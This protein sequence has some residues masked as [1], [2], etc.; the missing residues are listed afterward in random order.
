M[1]LAPFSNIRK[2]NSKA[3]DQEL[4]ESYIELGSVWKVAERFGMLGQSVHERLVKLEIRLKHPRITE[5]EK[6]LILEFYEKGFKTGSG[7]LKKFSES[8]GRTVPLISRTAKELGLSSLNRKVCDSQLERQSKKHKEWHLNNEHPRGMLGKTHSP[9]YC[10]EVGLRAKKQWNDFSSS[11][12]REVIFKSLKTRL[13]SQGT[14]APKKGGA[15]VSWK[16]GWRVIGSQSKY[17]R[18]RWEANYARYLE[19]LKV[20]GVIYDWLHE[21][22]TFWFDEIKR[23]CVTYLPDFKIIEKDGSHHWVEV[24]GWMD[25]RSK[26]KLSRFK[27]YYPNEKLRVVDAKWFK[28]NNRKMQGLIPTWEAG[29]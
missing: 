19:F 25:D 10:K 28:E 15:D 8:L 7:D 23:G 21:P 2:P 16:Q 3:S 17:Y 22:Q 1:T 14:L 11:R 26:T 9:E 29:K 24:K 18:S 4:I 6:E 20:N 12:K 27:K 13:E 5:R